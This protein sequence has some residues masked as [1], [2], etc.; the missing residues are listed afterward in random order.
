MSSTGSVTCLHGSEL[1]YRQIASFFQFL[2][3][4]HG[5]EQLKEPPWA[6]KEFL[7]CLHGSE[8]C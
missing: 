6:N 1:N 2:S 8:L 5:S 3:C 7:S 4:L